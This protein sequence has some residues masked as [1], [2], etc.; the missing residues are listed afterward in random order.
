VTH[1]AP[2]LTLE[3]YSPNR[4][5][6]HYFFSWLGICSDNESGVVLSISVGST[7]IMVDDLTSP[8]YIGWQ[9]EVFIG[10]FLPLQ[11]IAVAA[12]FYAQS[13]ADSKFGL[14]DWLVIASLLGQFVTGGICIG[15]CGS[16]YSWNS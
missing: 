3:Y 7:T 12:R 16:W 9:L 5:R 15:T 1:E 6:A 2:F 14:D 10:V 8:E 4:L 11:V 13:R